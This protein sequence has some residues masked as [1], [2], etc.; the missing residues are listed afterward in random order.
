MEN[1]SREQHFYHNDGKSVEIMI[2]LNLCLTTRIRSRLTILINFLAGLEY[3]EIIFSS[4]D[5]MCI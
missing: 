2:P 3:L 1:L 4:A 5:L